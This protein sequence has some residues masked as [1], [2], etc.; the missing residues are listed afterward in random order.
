MKAWWKESTIS[1]GNPGQLWWKQV[2]GMNETETYNLFSSEI[3]FCKTAGTLQ[4]IS[5]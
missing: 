5:V 4:V 1:K 3:N 2:Q